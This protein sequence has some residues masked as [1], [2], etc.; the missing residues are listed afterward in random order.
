MQIPFTKTGFQICHK[1]PRSYVIRFRNAETE[2][3]GLYTCKARNK[4]GT[5]S[6]SAM[7]YVDK[8]EK[9]SKR[10]AEE[11]NYSQLEKRQRPDGWS[12]RELDDYLYRIAVANYHIKYRTPTAGYSNLF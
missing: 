1:E 5:S 6:T 12:Q 9:L 4:I 2:D 10:W 3:S 11:L 7:V 8:P